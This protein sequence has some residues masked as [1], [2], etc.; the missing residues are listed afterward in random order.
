MNSLRYPVVAT[1]VFTLVVSLLVT[2]YGGLEEEYGVIP[3]A[4][5]DQGYDVMDAL[6]QTNMI[7]GSNDI[8]AAISDFTA[9]NANAF[10]ILGALATGAIG[11]LQIVGGIITFPAE[12]IGIVTGFYYIPPILT[13]M[14][15]IIFS[16]LILM[17]L[18]SA[19]LGKDV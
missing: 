15:P 6:N 13:V 4:V 5:N 16:F 7:A 8:L 12:I 10:D 2:I 17:I 18:I 1:F 19:K 9:P 14:V 3:Q 11:A